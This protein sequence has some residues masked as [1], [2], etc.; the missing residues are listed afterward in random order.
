MSSR[1]FCDCVIILVLFLSAYGLFCLIQN[2]W[3][4]WW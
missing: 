1:D 2:K 4:W 3:W